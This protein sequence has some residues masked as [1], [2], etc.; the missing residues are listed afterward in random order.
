M[1]LIFK[2]MFMG[3]EYRIYPDDFGTWS[4]RSGGLVNGKD[5][6][7]PRDYEPAGFYLHNEVSFLRIDTLYFVTAIDSTVIDSTEFISGVYKWAPFY[8]YVTHF[9]RVNPLRACDILYAVSS[10]VNK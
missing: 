5:I 2:D 3:T 1:K 9:E 10:K 8:D 7:N 4:G 6:G